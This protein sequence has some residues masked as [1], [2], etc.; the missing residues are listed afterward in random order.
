MSAKAAQIVSKSRPP[1]DVIVPT[2]FS[3]TMKSGTRPL[4]TSDSTRFQNG[5]KVPE[6]SPLNL[7][8]PPASDKSWQG[9]E[10]HTKLGV[11]GKSVTVT[12]LTSA[13]LR[14]S[15]PQF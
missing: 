15:A 13:V 1:W 6:R 2:T 4:A 14:F 8:L 3:K 9:K 7:A 12:V 11:P 10:A 5:Q